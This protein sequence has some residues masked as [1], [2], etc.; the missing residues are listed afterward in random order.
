[1]SDTDSH[2]LAVINIVRTC[3]STE[4]EVKAFKL[5][6]VTAESVV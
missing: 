2:I 4:Q 6:I 5:E 1:V 3:S